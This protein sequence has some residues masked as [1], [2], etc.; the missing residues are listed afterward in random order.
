METPRARGPGEGVFAFLMLGLALV[1]FWQSWRI[2]PVTAMSSPA[3]FPMAVSAVMALAALSTLVRT[4]R[5][6]RGG[7]TLARD[8]LPP[9]VLVAGALIGVFA[10]LLEP[11]GFIPAAGVYL[12]GSIAYLNRRGGLV[13]AALWSLVAL[14]AVYVVFRLVFK[15]VLPEGV[16]PERDIMAWIGGF[17]RGGEAGQ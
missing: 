6:K 1:L 15:V 17:F 2:G 10:L 13:P 16:V 8:V 14:V 4:L 12:L 9:V 11:A 3:V 5:M 7:G